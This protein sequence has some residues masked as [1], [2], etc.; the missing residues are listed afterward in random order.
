MAVLLTLLWIRMR[1]WLGGF[2]YAI[3]GCVLKSFHAD[4]F[5]AKFLHLIFYV[6]VKFFNC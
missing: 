6:F 5:S 3:I 1:S 4:R 2:L